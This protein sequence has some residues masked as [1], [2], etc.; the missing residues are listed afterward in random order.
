MEL[1]SLIAITGTHALERKYL[2]ILH[3]SKDKRYPPNSNHT[4]RLS[5]INLLDGKIVETI[6]QSGVLNSNWTQME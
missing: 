4:N 5:I 3:K 6:H 2:S 1:A